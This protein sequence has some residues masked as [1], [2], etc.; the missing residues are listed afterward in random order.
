MCW[1]WSTFA[2]MM[3]ELPVLHYVVYILFLYIL[4]LYILYIL[5]L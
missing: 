3:S 1:R 4:F 5:F 2:D